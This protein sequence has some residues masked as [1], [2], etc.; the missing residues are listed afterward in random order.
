[1]NADAVKAAAEAMRA[2][3]ADPDAQ[4]LN[5]EWD[6]CVCVACLPIPARL[7]VA[8]AEPIIRAAI[9]AEIRAM[10]LPDGSLDRM[11]GWEEAQD[12]PDLLRMAEGG[13]AARE[14]EAEKDAE[15]ARLRAALA[16]QAESVEATEAENRRLRGARR[17]DLR[18]GRR[19]IEQR[20]DAEHRAEKAEAAVERV[21]ALHPI[22]WP[23]S[24]Q[25]YGS[26]EATRAFR[27]GTL[28]Q[29]DATIAA[30]DGPERPSAPATPTTTT[31]EETDR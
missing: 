2:Y 27:D 15:I 25:K 1:V 16:L 8:A 23:T 30:L 28:A 11:A 5:E 29:R 19:L 14:R 22:L 9:A 10:R 26:M 6:G 4:P 13:I 7:A 3:V 12:V 31:A 20:D 21:R 24:P 17:E 18:S